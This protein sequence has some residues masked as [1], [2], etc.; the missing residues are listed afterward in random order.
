MEATAGAPLPRSLPDDA[1]VIPADIS[2]SKADEYL[3]EKGIFSDVEQA[4][5]KR[6]FIASSTITSY[7]FLTTT[8]TKTMSNIA[9]AADLSCLPTQFALC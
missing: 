6:L 3:V 4:R 8:S 2:S 1:I 7:I 9:A 5:E